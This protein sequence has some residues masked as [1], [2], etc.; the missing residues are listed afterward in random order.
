MEQARRTVAALLNC[1]PGEIIFT[2]GGTE[3]DNMVLNCAAR[4]LGVKHIITSRI[5]HHA[6]EYTAEAIA[7]SGDAEVHWV[8]L[9]ADGSRTSCILKIAFRHEGARGRSFP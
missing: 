7:R 9:E 3:A 5:E 6:I 2:S 1:A 4:D 8:R